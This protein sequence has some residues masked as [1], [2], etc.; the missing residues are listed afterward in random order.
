MKKN[1]FFLLL[2]VYSSAQS[3]IDS[4]YHTQNVNAF[5][6]LRGVGFSHEHSLGRNTTLFVG[7]FGATELTT[8]ASGT[9]SQRPLNW[10]FG[11]GLE[12]RMQ[13]RQYY[14]LQKR[15]RAGKPVSFNTGGYWGLQ[16]IYT[17]PGL[18]IPDPSINSWI[19]VGPVWGFQVVRRKMFLNINVGIVGNFRQTGPPAVSILAWPVLPHTHLSL[20]FFLKPKAKIPTSD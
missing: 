6:L 4:L 20:G 16:A 12:G 15:L 9:N 7:V 8:Q 14:N 10:T 1:M 13:L 11:L 18:I 2:L 19:R 3:Q 5:H 17:H